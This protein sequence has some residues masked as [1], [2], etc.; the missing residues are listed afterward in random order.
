MLR[1]WVSTEEIIVIDRLWSIIVII[2][3]ELENIVNVVFGFGSLTKAVSCDT[4][5]KVTLYT[6]TR[7]NVNVNICLGFLIWLR[8]IISIVVSRL[9]SHFGVYSGVWYI[10]TKE[11]TPNALNN[12]A[13]V[14]THLW[15]FFFSKLKMKTVLF[16]F[17][18]FSK[19]LVYKHIYVKL[20]N[21]VCRLKWRQQINSSDECYALR[22]IWYFLS[23][24]LSCTE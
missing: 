15:I 10:R 2:I 17:K 13:I 24:C 8:S 9:S 20:E 18:K 22:Q 1:T 21:W 12:H 14:T 3:I 23:D 7:W 6:E 11:N 5:I 16:H 19:L 4:G